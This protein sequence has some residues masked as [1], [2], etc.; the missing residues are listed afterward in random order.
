MGFKFGTRSLEQLE[1]CHP[2][3]QLIL[4]T[5]ISISPVDFGISEGHRSIERQ[6]KLFL[7]GK[8]KVD[9]INKKGKHNVYPSEAA[10]IYIYHTDP[11]IRRKLAYS[12]PHLSYVAG[13][14]MATAM[15][16]HTQE[17]IEHLIR[18]GA[19]WDGDGIIADDQAFDDFPHFELIKA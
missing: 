1:T 15:V 4:R 6:H 17:K 14:I 10:D 8:S 9:G 13:I 2:D 18:W 5:S 11:A 3:L 12:V 16:L 7:E 19:N